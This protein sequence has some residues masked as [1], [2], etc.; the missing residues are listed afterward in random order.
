MVLPAWKNDVNI[1]RPETKPKANQNKLIKCTSLLYSI[2]P[3]ILSAVHLC[4]RLVLFNSGADSFTA[5]T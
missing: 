5:S 3:P 4:V 2:K 1:G